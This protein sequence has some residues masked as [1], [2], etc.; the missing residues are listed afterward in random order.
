[1]ATARIIVQDALE[2]LQVRASETDLTADEVALAL[3]HYNRIVAEFDIQG[4]HLGA[5]LVTSAADETGLDIASEQL[6]VTH[7]ALSVASSFG[8]TPS[9]SIIAFAER[10]YENH[11]KANQ[12]PPVNMPPA[13]MPLGT[14]VHGQFHS[15][16]GRKFAG[17]RNPGIAVTDG[18]HT[19]T[20]EQGNII[21]T[22]DPKNSEN[23]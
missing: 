15:F 12:R 8:I 9:N 23:H 2:S 4:I 16:R 5:N 7:L 20:D 19:L 1:M 22:G 6:I 3:R 10:A 11:L 18:G 14:G 17:S 21:L 13:N